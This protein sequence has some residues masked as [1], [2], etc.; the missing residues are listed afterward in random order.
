MIMRVI[1]ICT[2]IYINFPFSFVFRKTIV[3]KLSKSEDL[4]NIAEKF[5]EDGAEKEEI[6][7]AGSEMFLKR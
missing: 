1:K 2:S 7:E 5:L 4:Q 3:G 6:A